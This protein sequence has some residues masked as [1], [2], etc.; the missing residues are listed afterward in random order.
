M[1]NTASFEDVMRNLRERF[2]LLAR[3]GESY[4]RG[5]RAERQRRLSE[6]VERPALPAAPATEGRAERIVMTGFVTTEDG[7]EVVG[8]LEDVPLVEAG[9]VGEGEE[10]WD[11]LYGETY[12][13]GGR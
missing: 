5:A 4:G 3:L 6:V 9:D 1:T 10:E 11:A 12:A 2:P 13:V 8:E 7:G